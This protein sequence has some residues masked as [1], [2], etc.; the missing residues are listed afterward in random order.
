MKKT[1]PVRAGGVFLCAV[2]FRIIV[3]PAK[4]DISGAA[5]VP[6]G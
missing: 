3:I 5:R 4:A 2:R 1:P 6:A